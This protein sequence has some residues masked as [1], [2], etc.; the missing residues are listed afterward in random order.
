MSRTCL[1]ALLI[2][3][4]W[5]CAGEPAAPGPETAAPAAS[6]AEELIARSIAYHDPGGRWGSAEI[7]LRIMESR[8]NG[9]LRAVDVGMAPGR[10]AMEVS[11]ETDAAVVSFAVGG[12]EILRRAVDANEDLDAETLAGHGLDPERVMWLRNYYLFVWGLPMKLRDPGTIVDPEPAPDSYDGREALKV[13]VTYDPEVGSDTWY[14]YFDPESARLIGYRFYHDE[15]AND[16]EYI[17]L[18]GEIESGRLRLPARRRWF[19][20]SNDEFLGE[21]EAVS[22]TVTP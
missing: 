10:G 21:D 2:A 18:E 6:A 7:A 19:F 15:S 17:R 16:G 3:S 5:G 22:L 4:F 11:R 13:R 20:H 12:E 8:P 1:N 14:F 9:V